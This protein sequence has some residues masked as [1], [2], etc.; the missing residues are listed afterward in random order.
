MP[1]HCV[2]VN[3]VCNYF[4]T[5]VAAIFISLLSI[6]RYTRKKYRDSVRERK[7][8]S[9]DSAFVMVCVSHTFLMC[10]NFNSTEHSHAQSHF[11][12][13][14]ILFC[15]EYDEKRHILPLDISTNG[16]LRSVHHFFWPLVT[17]GLLLHNST[18]TSTSVGWTMIK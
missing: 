6:C 4:A 5:A 12:L 16:R 8:M 2:S 7:K 1:Y 18:E 17:D 13:N 10:K 3:T 11:S 9:D 14:L 15:C